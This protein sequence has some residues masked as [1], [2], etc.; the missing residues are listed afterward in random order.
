MDLE[1][2]V[3]RIPK[4][5]P[6]T[7]QEMDDNLD[8]LRDAIQGLAALFGV[9]LNPDGSLKNPPFVYGASATGNDTYVITPTPTITS[10]ASLL[11]RLVVLL[12][13]VANTGPATL[14]IDTLGA[15]PIKK[16]FNQALDS[17]DIKAAQVALLS[18]DGTNFQMQSWPGVVQPVNYALDTGAVN[19]YAVVQSGTIAV[20][21]AL[22]VGYKIAVKIVTTNTGPST[23]QIGAL[24]ATPI[25]KNVATALSAGDLVVGQIADFIYDGTNFQLQVASGAVVPLTAQPLP[26]GVGTL[27][28][29]H[30][31]PRTPSIVRAVLLCT[32]ADAGFVINDE[33]D[34]R[35]VY[36]WTAPEDQ[37]PILLYSDAVNVYVTFNAFQLKRPEPYT[38]MDRAKYTVK[39]YVMP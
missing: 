29:V 25:K 20:P 6:L 10:M 39:V 35:G 27:T 8:A 37:I 38:D 18:W 9:A 17:G 34:I 7:P 31:M 19:A 1:D 11:G 33:I 22:Y 36:L 12:V 13:D 4:G 21:N 24:A 23:L 26:A 14:N 2:L 16:F 5:S 32:A 28:F 30:G 3:L 15:F